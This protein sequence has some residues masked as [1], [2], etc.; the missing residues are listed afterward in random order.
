MRLIILTF[1]SFN[2]T[3][4]P[5]PDFFAFWKEVKSKHPQVSLTTA[6]FYDLRRVAMIPEH[7]FNKIVLSSFDY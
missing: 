2:C 6:I 7:D 3:P 1:R 4:L 5:W